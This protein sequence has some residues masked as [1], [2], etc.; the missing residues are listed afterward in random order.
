MDRLAD[1]INTIKTNERIGRRECAVYSTKLTR[2]VLDVMQ[3]NGY[4][5]G[6]EEYTERYAHMLKVKLSRRIN[7]IGV[8]KPRYSIG[9]ADIQRYEERYIPSK[10]FGILVLSTPKGL[11]TNR[12]ARAEGTGG[13]LIAYVY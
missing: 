2:A 6:Y 3:K 5:E 4:I 13:R 8:A 10:D 7:S 11:L 12:E 9:K 1:A